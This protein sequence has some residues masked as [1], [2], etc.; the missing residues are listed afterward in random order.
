MLIIQFL[1]SFKYTN[2][3]QIMMLGLVEIQG[4]TVEEAAR[5]WIEQNENV[6]RAWIP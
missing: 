2:E 3:D 5:T 6:W 4:K 1:R